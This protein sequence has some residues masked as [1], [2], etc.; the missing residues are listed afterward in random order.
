MI[1]LPHLPEMGLA[2]LTEKGAGKD[3]AAIL[4]SGFKWR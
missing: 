1:R 3:G 4:S 2:E